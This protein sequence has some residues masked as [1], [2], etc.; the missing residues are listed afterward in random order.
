M[1]LK[2][3]L[4]ITIS[5]LSIFAQSQTA[6]LNANL[7]YALQVRVTNRYLHYHTPVDFQKYNLEKIK[8]FEEISGRSNTDENSNFDKSLTGIHYFYNRRIIDFDQNGNPVKFFYFYY[9]RDE[10]KTTFYEMTFLYDGSGLMSGA[11]IYL[12]DTTGKVDWGRELL[13]TINAD[14]VTTIRSKNIMTV[15]DWLP[16]VNYQVIYRKNGSIEQ[17]TDSGHPLSFSFDEKDRMI[18]MSLIPSVYSYAFTKEGKIA[19]IT[20]TPMFEDPITTKF[21]YDKNGALLSAGWGDQNI[22]KIIDY[23]NGPDGLPLTAREVIMMSGYIE[24]ITNYEYRYT[25]W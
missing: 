6:W 12:K 14:K 11:T 1:K 23:R 3:A 16:D 22:S 8:S 13:F 24:D 19:T 7:F 4:F 18:S 25:K 17:I 10:G 20:E 21:N 5:S 15:P 9:D 2:T